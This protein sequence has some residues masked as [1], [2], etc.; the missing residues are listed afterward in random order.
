VIPERNPPHRLPI[1]SPFLRKYPLLVI[2]R[3]DVHP[4]SSIRRRSMFFASL[5]LH[6]SSVIEEPQMPECRHISEVSPMTVKTA[7][8]RGS[9]QR[10]PDSLI[11]K[12]VEQHLESVYQLHVG[13]L[14]DVDLEQYLGWC[15]GVT[16]WSNLA[17]RF[18]SS[19][20]K[21][22]KTVHAATSNRDLSGRSFPAIP[23][24]LASVGF[25]WGFH[26]GPLQPWQ[27]GRLI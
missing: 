12:H 25:S 27:L 21:S 10:S 2:Q 9:I 14:G 18:A 4:E 23:L 22:V 13:V 3:H 15:A 7:T 17:I 20:D 5:R 26:W 24:V 6:L 8:S 19:Q 1:G 11:W 16:V